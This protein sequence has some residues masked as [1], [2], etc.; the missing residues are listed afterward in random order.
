[1]LHY[2]VQ[3]TT[4]MWQMKKMQNTVHLGDASFK[5]LWPSPPSQGTV[6][7]SSVHVVAL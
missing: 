1:M 3:E 4:L 6:S 5:D 2:E 7:P